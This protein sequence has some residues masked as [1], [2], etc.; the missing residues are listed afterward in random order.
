V[1]RSAHSGRPKQD[2]SD[3]NIKKVHKI[4]LNDRK[5]KLIE[6]SETLNISKKRVEHIVHGYL[7]M[8]KLCSKLVPRVLKIDQNQQRVDDSEQCLAIFNRNKDEIFRRY[9]TMD[10]TWLLHN[11]LESNRQS[12]E[13]T[14]RDEPNPKRGKTQR[15]AGVSIVEC[16]WYYVLRLPRKE[17]NHQQRVLHGVIGVFKCN[18]EK[19]GSI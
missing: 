8:Q 17:P 3:E 13:W 9:I 6:I 5:V 14:E 1:H 16:A 4:I 2:I 18:Q 12:A 7:D 10:V 19:N 11:T 15:A